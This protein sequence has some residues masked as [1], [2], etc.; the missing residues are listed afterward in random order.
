M[1]DIEAA[2]QQVELLLLPLVSRKNRRVGGGFQS[3]HHKGI[4]VK[5]M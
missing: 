2:R 1:S 5:L 3:R 4:N